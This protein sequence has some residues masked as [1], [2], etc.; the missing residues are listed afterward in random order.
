MVAEAAAAAR[1]QGVGLPEG[2]VEERSAFARGLP[3]EMR[4]SMLHDLEAGRRLELDWLTGG[5]GCAWEL[6]RGV[7]SPGDLPRL[8]EALAPQR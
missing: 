8:Y 5:R 4:P 2:I 7:A 1:A 3:R 6:R